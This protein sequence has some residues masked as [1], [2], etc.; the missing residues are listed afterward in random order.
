V[1]DAVGNATNYTYD[2]RGRLIQEQ[3]PLGS[4]F[5]QYD[6]VIIGL[7]VKIVRVELRDMVMTIS[8]V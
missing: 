5:Y 2:L 6:L 1:T 4:R 3:S 7:R 8:T